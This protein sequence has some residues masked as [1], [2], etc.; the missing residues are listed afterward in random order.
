M[1]KLKNRIFLLGYIVLILINVTILLSIA[2]GGCEVKPY[3]NSSKLMPKGL[4]DIYLG[5]DE[6]E[7]PGIQELGGYDS[8]QNLAYV[9]IERHLGIEN[10]NSDFIQEIWFDDK[11][12]SYIRFS[13]EGPFGY[14]IGFLAGGIEKWGGDFEK[15]IEILKVKDK[16]FYYPMLYWKKKDAKIFASYSYPFKSKRIVSDSIYY[17]IEYYT[18]DA[19]RLWWSNG[20]IRRVSKEQEIY[21]GQLDNIDSLIKD[22]DGPK[23]Q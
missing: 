22:Y 20:K 10:P 16:V 18:P 14:L 4:E 6:T 9:Y 7:V 23:F 19:I 12:F 17:E 15:R 11:A 21:F 1:N 3:P 8:E 2:L 5:M 13:G